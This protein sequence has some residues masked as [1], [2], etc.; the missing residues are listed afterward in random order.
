[1]LIPFLFIVHG[2]SIISH[3]SNHCEQNI[4][5]LFISCFILTSHNIE[6]KNCMTMAYFFNISHPGSP[7]QF[8][9]YFSTILSLINYVSFSLKYGDTESL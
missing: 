7:T 6:R 2:E 1:M 8:Y 4:K 5:V 3:Q 9:N